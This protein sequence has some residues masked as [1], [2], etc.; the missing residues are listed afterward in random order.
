MLAILS[1]GCTSPWQE[2]RPIRELRIVET[3][4]CDRKDDG[5]TLSAYAAQPELKLRQTAPSIRLAMDQMRNQAASPALFFAHTEFLLLGQA[6]AEDGLAPVLDLVGRSQDMRLR[7][8]YVDIPSE[9]IG[10]VETAIRTRLK[11]GCKNL[12]VLVNYTA[13]YSTREILAKM[14]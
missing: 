9:L 2:T 7:M 14:K 4:G 1:C 8:K 13:L 5:V 6:L 11:D 12:Y 10:D 3:L